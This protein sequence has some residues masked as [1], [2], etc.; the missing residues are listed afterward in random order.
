[1][2]PLQMERTGWTLSRWIKITCMQPFYFDVQYYNTYV[3]HYFMYMWIGFVNEQLTEQQV[4]VVSKIGNKTRYFIPSAST[5][6][7]E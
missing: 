7:T 6:F 4:N 2:K 3:S 1:M 5:H